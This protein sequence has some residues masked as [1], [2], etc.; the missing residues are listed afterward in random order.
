MKTG[1]AIVV[2]LLLAGVVAAW[3]F[4][5]VRQWFMDFESYVKSLGALGPLYQSLSNS[6]VFSH[7]DESSTT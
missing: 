5:P 2:T 1:R 6:A 7:H 3:L 4:L